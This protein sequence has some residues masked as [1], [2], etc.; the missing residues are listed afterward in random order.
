MSSSHNRFF[1]LLLG[2]MVLSCG[3]LVNRGSEQ[4]LFDEVLNEVMY[5]DPLLF[6]TMATDTSLIVPESAVIGRGKFDYAQMKIG[7]SEYLNDASKM[8]DRNQHFEPELETLIWYLE[9]VIERE[10]F[11]LHHYPISSIHGVHLDIP[12]HFV[13]RKIRTRNDVESYLED[14]TAVDQQFKELIDE[15]ELR[16]VTGF[17]APSTTLRQARLVCDRIVL[18][19]AEENP[20][21]VS[22]ERSL[23]SIGLLEPNKK[24]EYLAKCR[25]IL[26]DRIIPSFVRLSNYLA[27]LEETA[28]SVAG[29]W[30][31][32]DGKAFYSH[33]LQW[34]CG[35]DVHP[36]SLYQ[37]AKRE[38]QLI[39]RTAPLNAGDSTR[40]L[41]TSS[42]SFGLISANHQFRKLLPCISHERGYFLYKDIK[43]EQYELANRN[44]TV[45][46]LVDLGIHHKR[47]IREQ[48]IQF[49][50]DNT[51][52]E[53]SDAES[54]VDISI[55]LPG[56]MAAEKIGELVLSRLKKEHPELSDEKFE[57]HITEFGPLPLS[58]VRKV[59]MQKP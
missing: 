36:D 7:A 48:A 26:M 20:I 40:T 33:C 31:L 57:E 6:H 50:L 47:W 3:S 38:L 54:I 10:K 5:S 45:K 37:T 8:N 23:N 9:N 34:Y 25:E 58:V 28:T 42:A 19:P 11:A 17:T 52:L 18:L 51:Q 21:Y 12:E 56:L 27:Q 53:L 32:K 1:F 39:D 59:M 4:Q 13:K 29:V 14:L 44:A 55:S 16:R 46:L 2:L 35:M 41:K 15:L 22:Y 24:D 43:K 49:I 30:Q